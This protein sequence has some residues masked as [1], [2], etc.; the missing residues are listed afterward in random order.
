MDNSVQKISDEI[1]QYQLY[2]E[3]C[4]KKHENS[5]YQY[6]KKTLNYITPSNPSYVIL[7]LKAMGCEN[8]LRNRGEIK[9]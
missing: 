3:E 7:S 9:K 8:I 4:R 6:N 2:S 1:Y 5:I